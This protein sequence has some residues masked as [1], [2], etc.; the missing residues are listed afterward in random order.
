MGN[1]LQYKGELDAAIDSHKQ[2]IKIKPD[3]AEAYNNMG[4][5]LLDKGELDAAIDR[6]KQAIKIKPDYA[7]CFTNC[8]SILVQV[9]DASSLDG[10]LNPNANKRL[11][12]SLGES[13]TYQIQ[14]LIRY[15]LRGDYEEAKNILR[16][17][18][19][20]DGAGK[21]KDLQK[22]DQVFCSAYAN[23]INNLIKKRP[24]AP[25]LKTN[26]IYH[27]GESHC[28]SYAHHSLRIKHNTSVV[29]PKITF[30]A[31]ACHFSV[32]DENAFKSITKRNLNNTPNNSLVFVSFGEIDCRINEGFISASQKTGKSLT[33][34][35]QRTVFGYVKWFCDVNVSNKHRYIF[36][37]VPAPCYSNK[38][39]LDANQ[40]ASNVIRL[41]NEV[42]KKNL[43]E[44]SYDL[45]DV[46]EPT[47]AEN[48][49]S[50]GLYHCDNVHLDCSILNIIQ[51][52]IAKGEML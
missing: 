21:T 46:Y 6:H 40:D 41:F 33:E 50:N 13:P 12:S 32:P 44:Y 17:Y 25:T 3:N 15:F 18:E 24:A 16:N 26:E 2:A 20:L 9:S 37:N 42:L 38:F 45:I 23:F 39:T 43:E 49:F 51:D 35:I 47:K 4:I 11:K 7:D 48:S 28:L 34:L 10:K 29:S 19:V 27:V 5:A 30:G 31:K 1:A 8:D 14:Q 52:Q 36:F 22:K